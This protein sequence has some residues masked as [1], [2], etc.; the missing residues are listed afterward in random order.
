MGEDAGTSFP[1][2]ALNFFEGVRSVVVFEVRG[3]D[4]N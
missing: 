3:E 2:L 1:A 4:P